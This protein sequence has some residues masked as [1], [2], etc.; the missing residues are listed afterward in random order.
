MT[1]KR[2]VVIRSN[3]L[4]AHSPEE[5]NRRKNLCVFPYGNL[6]CACGDTDLGAAVKFMPRPVVIGFTNGI[7]ILI[8]STQIRALFGLKVEKLPREFVARIETFALHFATFSLTTTLLAGCALIGHTRLQALHEAYSW[9]HCRAP[10]GKRGRRPQKHLPGTSRSL[11][12]AREVYESMHQLLWP[13]SVTRE[14]DFNQRSPT[15][16]FSSGLKRESP[17]AVR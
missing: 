9:N 10:A 13:G 1:E 4:A 5:A 16:F 11:E 14:E 17:V 15:C 12:R 2:L 3:S 8:A 7:A 6:F